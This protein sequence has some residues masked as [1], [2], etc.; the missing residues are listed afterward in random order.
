MLLDLI[1]DVLDL[2]RLDA[3]GVVFEDVAVDLRS[4]LVNTTA[5]VS[6]RAR[7][8]GIQLQTSV[9]DDVPRWIHGDPTRLRQILLNLTS[10]AA[11]FT[12]DGGIRVHIEAAG[13]RYRIIVADTGIGIP[14]AAQATLF[15]PFVQAEA[16]TTRRFGGSGLGLSIV[17]RLVT[18]MGGS[19]TVHSEPDAGSTFTVELPL[20]VSEAPSAAPSFVPSGGFDRSLR[21]LVVDDNPVNRMVASRML[22]KLGHRV[23]DVESGAEALCRLRETAF[24]AVFMDV[25][26]PDMDG[27]TAT[28]ALRQ[29]PGPASATVVIGLT[30]N[31]LPGDRDAVLEAGMDDYL[32]KPVR[33]QDL[34]AA[35]GRWQSSGELSRTA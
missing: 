28:R 1:N 8:K 35:L 2:S 7:A 4:L 21:V 23:V 6:L 29:L 30:A 34:Q 25:Q 14:T 5:P 16:S 17:W 15:E 10:N 18:G 31:A 32:A 19:I 22:A 26:M 24:D 9:A 20:A 12:E 27:L 11:K 33:L 13:D 3:G